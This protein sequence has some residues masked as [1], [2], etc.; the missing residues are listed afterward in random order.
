MILINIIVPVC[1][2]LAVTVV[3]WM[4]INKYA[5]KAR[6]P[7]LVLI[8]TGIGWFLGFSIIIFIPLDIQLTILK[9][10]VFR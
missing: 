5:D 9:E 1:E 2:L 6:T 10:Q 4:L 3:I 7:L 8:L